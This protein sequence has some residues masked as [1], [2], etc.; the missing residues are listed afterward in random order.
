MGRLLIR[1][2]GV[3]LP[4]QAHARPDREPKL[5]G[6]RRPLYLLE[7]AGD[8]MIDDGILD[9][10]YGGCTPQCKLGPHCGDGIVNGPEECD[11][12]VDNGKNGVCSATCKRLCI[13]P[14]P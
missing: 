13:C 9:G 4:A 3:V 6:F 10:S 1:R 12:G 5:G 8:S 11:H 7:V 2:S 14:T